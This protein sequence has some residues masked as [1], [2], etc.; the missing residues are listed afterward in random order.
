MYN[1]KAYVNISNQYIPVYALD[2][3]QINITNQQIGTIYPNECFGMHPTE[4]NYPFVTFRNSSGSTSIG[5]FATNNWPTMVLF[6]ERKSNGT[7]LLVN[8]PD[9]EGYYQ[10]T[11]SKNMNWYIGGELQSPYLPQGTIVK[12]S[13]CTTGSTHYYRM[14]CKQA[15]RPGET[16]FTELNPNG[17]FWVDFLSTG[18]MPSNRSMW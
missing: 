1:G 9:N 7:S 10:H 4:G 16:Q 14:A 13:D 6:R 2:S 12:V 3:S 15:K 18:S 5:A 17:I 11:L 8:S